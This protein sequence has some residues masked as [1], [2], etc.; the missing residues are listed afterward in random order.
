MP[1]KRGKSFVASGYDPATK[2]KRHLGTFPTAK[3]AREVEAKWRLRAKGTGRETCDQF[4]ARWTRDYPRDRLSTNLHNAQQVR[5][6]AREFKNV[7]L[8]DVD[9][10]VARA[11]A[12]KHPSHLPAVRAM[13][14][15]AMR[16]GLIVANPFSNLRL[17]GSRGRKDII[18]LTEQ[19]LHGLADMALD[20]RMELGLYA[21]EYRAMVLFAGYVGLRPGELFALRREDLRGELVVIERSLSSKTHEIGPT[22]NGKARTVIV[23]PVAQ[24]ALRDVPAHENGLLFVSPAGRMWTQPS[25]HRYWSRLRLLANRPGLDLYELRHACCTMLLSRGV[26][27]WDVAIQMGH[28]DGG[29]LVQLRYGHP[30]HAGVRSR[31]LAAYGV[32]DGPVAAPTPLGE[33]RRTA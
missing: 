28:E 18:A 24:E 33:K 12:L 23:P 27:P 10:P 26:T 5:L 15:D 16:D 17:P 14:G 6:F 31:L 2:Q 20:P 4:A 7:R 32:S 8:S 22:K 1:R 11:W 19:E 30:E 13:F 9:R 3:E 21:P 29:R 25:N